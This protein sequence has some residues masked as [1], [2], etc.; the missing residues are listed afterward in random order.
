MTGFLLILHIHK[1]LFLGMFAKLQTATF[2]SLCLSVHLSVHMEELDS[3]WMDFY[4]IWYLSIFWICV[5]KIQISLQSHKNN[6]YFTWRHTVCTFILISHP[7]ILRMRN[8]SDKIIEKMKT[9]ILCSVTFSPKLYSLWDNLEKYD[10]ARQATDNKIMWSG[11]FACW[12]SKA[13]NTH[14]KFTAF[15]WQWWLCALLLHYMYIA[16]L[17]LFITDG[18]GGADWSEVW[19][20]YYG[21][22]EYSY[23]QWW[24]GSTMGKSYYIHWTSV[25]RSIYINNAVVIMVHTLFL[26][27][28]L[29]N[30]RYGDVR[31]MMCWNLHILVQWRIQSVGYY[32]WL[33]MLM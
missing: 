29:S 15:T 25:S 9:H 16:F 10:T 3:H 33:D 4:E 5:K 6:G 12:I 30:I 1:W 26:M 13:S 18:F 24:L 2:S 8:A 17:V 31:H 32:E 27:Y 7:F 11:H 19:P 21:P 14:S 23:R 20:K 22:S 28:N